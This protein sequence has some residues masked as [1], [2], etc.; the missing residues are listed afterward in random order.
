MTDTTDSGGITK[1]PTV[2]KTTLTY[3][4]TLD[5]EIQRQIEAGI[6]N[7]VSE[8]FREAAEIHSIMMSRS[9][10][11]RAADGT[12]FTAIRGFGSGE[13]P[14]M[15]S[16]RTSVSVHEHHLNAAKSAVDI[17][18]VGS[19][20]EWFRDAALTR[21]VI[22]QLSHRAGGDRLNDAGVYNGE[23]TA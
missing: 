11:A 5:E 14:Q 12:V 17:G 10:G 16:K 8:W 2:V 1:S 21:L 6:N 22:Q 15:A 3:P 7:S 23:D 4:E 13:S 9:H 18:V 20:S 19:K